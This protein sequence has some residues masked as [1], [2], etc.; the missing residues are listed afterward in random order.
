MV[1]TREALYGKYVGNCPIVIEGRVLPA[2]LAVF[3]MMGFDVI[4]GMDWLSK[5]NANMDCR[6]KEITFQ[7]HGI[8]EFTYCGSRVR[9]TPPLL[10][11]NQALKNVRDGA[12][13]YLAYAQAKP[14]TQAKLEN[15]LIVCHYTNIFSEVIGLPSDREVEFSIDLVPGT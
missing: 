15:I 2:K 5:Y 8:E 4:L 1:R 3:G 12:R 11:A 7:L 6:R 10:S 13:A 14:E 9:Y